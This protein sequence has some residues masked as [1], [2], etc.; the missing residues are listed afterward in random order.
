MR[1]S[2]DEET[3]RN[4]N[5]FK[6]QLKQSKPTLVNAVTAKL[7]G[8]TGEKSMFVIAPNSLIWIGACEGKREDALLRSIHYHNNVLFR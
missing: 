7:C 5:S 6:C 1:R 3:D 8:A 4:Q 2:V